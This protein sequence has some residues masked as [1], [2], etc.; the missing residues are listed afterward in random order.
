MWE[1][2][3]ELRDGT[4]SVL[5]CEPGARGGKVGK[6]TSLRSSRARGTLTTFAKK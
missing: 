4:E 2:K 3:K 6:L 5:D 1:E